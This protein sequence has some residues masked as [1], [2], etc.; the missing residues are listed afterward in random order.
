M[1]AT[2]YTVSAVNNDNVEF[3]IIPEKRH[4]LARDF[5]DDARIQNLGPCYDCAFIDPYWKWKKLKPLM[6][7]IKS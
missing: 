2:V 5:F 6:Q 3:L 1:L 4:K 7:K